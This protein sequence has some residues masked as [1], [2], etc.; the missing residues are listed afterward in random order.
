M[1]AI[2]VMGLITVVCLLFSVTAWAQNAPDKAYLQKIWDAWG[3]MQM[4]NLDPYYATG[5]HTFFDDEPLK[6]TSWA[7]YRTTAAKEFE[8]YKSCK[9]TLNDDVQIHKAGT[10]YWGTAT[11]DFIGKKKDGKEE[12]ATL[13][14]TFVLEQLKGKWVLVHEHVSAPTS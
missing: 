4:E 3:T 12:K 14:W 9:F 7:E 11:L 6:F 2:R 1:K 5:A 13:R 8:E 10:M